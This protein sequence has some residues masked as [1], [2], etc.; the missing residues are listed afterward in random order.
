M[1]RADLRVGVALQVDVRDLAHA[2][3][4]HGEDRVAIGARSVGI[5][6]RKE[7][8]GWRDRH[9]GVRKHQ[10]ALLQSEQQREGEI[11]ASRVTRHEHAPRQ[12]CAGWAVFAKPAVAEET[13]VKTGRVRVLGSEAVGDGKDGAASGSREARRERAMRIKTARSPAAAMDVEEP[14]IRIRAGGEQPLAGHVF[15]ANL[16]HLGLKVPRRRMRIAE[17]V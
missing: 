15:D 2:I 3:G 9:R 16:T 11:S 7:I 6:R 12:A 5:S 10:S 4:A 8:G 13:V 14:A 17:T 1:R